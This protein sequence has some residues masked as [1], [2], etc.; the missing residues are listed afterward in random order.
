MDAQYFDDL[1]RQLSSRR[2]AIGGLLAGL[3]LPLDAAAR[4]K[5]KRKDK[6]KAKDK[7]KDQKRANAQAEPCWRA[8]AC[9]PKKGANVSQCDLAGYSPTTTLNC[10]GC[11]LSRANLR[12]ADL[13]GANFTKANL[14]GACLI[15]ADFTGATFANNTNLANAI[16]CNTTMPNGSVND[17]GCGSGTACCSTCIEIGDTCGGS[18]GSSC[19]DGGF[20]GSGACQPCPCTG[21]GEVCNAQGACVCAPGW[22]TLFNGSCGYPC[23]SDAQCQ[24]IGCMSCPF[25]HDFCISSWTENECG[26]AGQDCP[27]GQVCNLG[28]CDVLCGPPV[29]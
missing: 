24:A 11:N 13:S 10:T 29:N 7:G 16:F 12:G 27:A 1:T 17:S 3:L 20:C 5:S 26:V 14:S 28:M 2:T 18:N 8:G 23:T 22:T 4:G 15:D 19:C 9:M 21:A 6:G 25:W